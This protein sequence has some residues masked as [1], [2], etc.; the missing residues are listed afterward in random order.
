MTGTRREETSRYCAQFPCCHPGPSAGSLP[1]CDG[2]HSQPSYFSFFFHIFLPSL[3][4]SFTSH[5]LSSP[6][7]CSQ[8]INLLSLLLSHPTF[9]STCHCFPSSSSV[10]SIDFYFQLLLLLLLL[11]FGTIY[12]PILHLLFVPLLHTSHFPLNHISFHLPFVPSASV[13]PASIFPSFP[14]SPS[15]L[16]SPSSSLSTS[17]VHTS[18]SIISLS[19]LQA[20]AL[21]HIHHFL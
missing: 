2:R 16:T 13:P 15:N 3:R 5:S 21:T 8:H 7:P 11:S 18:N 10:L 14:Y 12:I 20:M 19:L 1:I 6:Y 17:S 9:L 4:T